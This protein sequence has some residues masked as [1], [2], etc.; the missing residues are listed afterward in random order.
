MEFY[1]ELY[2]A[3]PKN[4]QT[5]LRKLWTES[6]TLP[7][8]LIDSIT[9]LIT[10][11][12][13]GDKQFKF[14]T[15]WE[16]YT[17]ALDELLQ[18][19]F[20]EHPNICLF[21]DEFPLFF[22]H[23]ADDKRTGEIKKILTSLRSWRQGGLA[24]G[25]VGSLNLHHQL[26]GLDIS[27]KY[28][29]GLNSMRLQPFEKEVA[30]E[31]ILKLKQGKSLDWWT[32]ETTE[33]ILDLL[34]DY[35]PYF[36]QLAFHHVV[37]NQGKNRAELEHIF[38]NEIFPAFRSDF[39]YQ[40]DERLGRQFKTS[41]QLKAAQAILDHIVR[42]KSTTFN[43]LQETLKETFQYDALNRLVDYEFLTIEDQRYRFSLEMLRQW[44]QQ[45]RNL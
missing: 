17:L 20:N 11:V 19:F 34:P 9:N 42:H 40:F 28:L 31:L 33:T 24:M 32:D 23:L 36:I 1:Q 39:I 4:L 5:R 22:E 14:R 44:W 45:K 30:K 21:L 15:E 10:E 6:K 12:S 27:R 29:A 25:L 41:E 38:H 43:E 26:E 16:A 35:V 8:Q 7:S 37:T 3:L 18:K 13:I 2:H